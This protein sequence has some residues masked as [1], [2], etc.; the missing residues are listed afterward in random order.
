[1]NCPVAKAVKQ[2][3]LTRYPFVRWTGK[4]RAIRGVHPF[5]IGQKGQ[6]NE[7]RG[8]LNLQEFVF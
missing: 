5:F 2:M 7:G 3:V 8:S 6:G 1:M 4:S